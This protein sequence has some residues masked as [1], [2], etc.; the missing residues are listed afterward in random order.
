LRTAPKQRRSKQTSSSAEIAE[1]VRVLA[2][3]LLDEPGVGVIVG[4]QLLVAWSHH[5]LI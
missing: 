5:G 4:A 2:S 3:A 1:H